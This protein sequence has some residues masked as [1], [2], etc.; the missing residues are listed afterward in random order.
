MRPLSA[1]LFFPVALLLL[2]VLG[3]IAEV[4]VGADS[5]PLPAL[6]STNR[7]AQGNYCYAMNCYDVLTC[8]V[9][10]C[11]FVPSGCGPGSYVTV[12]PSCASDNTSVGWNYYCASSDTVKLKNVPGAT[13]SGGDGGACV[14]PI[15]LCGSVIINCVCQDGSPILIDV[16]GTG[17]QL[18]SQANG[19]YFDLTA[20]GTPKLTAWTAL[21]SANAFLCLDRNGNGTIDNGTELFGNVTPQPSSP[22]PNGFA[23]LAVY[24]L[25]QN[26]GNG[27]GIIDQRDAIFSKLLLWQDTNHNGI[28]EPSELHSLSE[29]GVAAISLRYQLS[30]RR[31]QYDNWFRYRSM[32]FD[33][34]GA[35]DGR[36][37]YDVFFNDPAQ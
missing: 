21:G 32:I 27:D 19:V 31:D 33:R 3:L 7:D 16:R 12:H 5:C 6:C 1:I 24:D 8:T 9:S 36:L 20:T 29:L 14:P 4:R 35:H 37:A 22:N 18:T 15:L 26:G 2:V 13:C 23:A 34:F 25:P 17:F 10:G 11:E 30:W 28:S